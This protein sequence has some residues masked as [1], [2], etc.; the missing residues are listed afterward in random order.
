MNIFTQNFADLQQL[1][2]YQSN[3]SYANMLAAKPTGTLNIPPD[4]Q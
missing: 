3:L 2:T 1:H 4:N